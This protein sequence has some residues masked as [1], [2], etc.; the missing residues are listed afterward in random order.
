MYLM[1]NKTNNYTTIISELS[2]VLGAIKYMQKSNDWQEHVDI[3]Y[4]YLGE[5]V[6]K[7]ARCI[8]LLQEEISKPHMIITTNIS[9]E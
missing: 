7:Q 3:G 5:L 8:A 6:E 4:Q 9:Y 1:N 2:E